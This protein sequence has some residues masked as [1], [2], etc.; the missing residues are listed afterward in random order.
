[1]VLGC[2]LTTT[3]SRVVSTPGPAVDQPRLTRTGASAVT[4]AFRQ[5]GHGI[6]GQL[7]FT[8]ECATESTSRVERKRVTEHRTN[9]GTATAWV[10]AGSLLTAVG[11]GTIIAGGNA[12]HRVSCGEMMAGDQCESDSSLLKEAGFT[13]LL[14]GLVPLATGAIFLALKP[15]TEI[16]Q[17]PAESVTTL[18]P[19]PTACGNTASLEGISVLVDTASS[20]KWSGR[21]SADGSLRIE[22][23]SQVPLPDNTQ[24]NVTVES[25]PPAIA[26]LLAPG[27]ALGSLTLGA[28]RQTSSERVPRKSGR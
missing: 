22:I 2:S 28:D 4:G 1:M 6:V 21:V 8:S 27:A 15:Q 24:V 25:V 3:T 5:Q 16:E 17:L 13:T 23:N 7:A 12:D 9:S 14:T 18:T 26:G 11:V 10:V 20:G 19:K